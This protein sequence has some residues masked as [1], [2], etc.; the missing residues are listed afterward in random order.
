ML[1]YFTAGTW[2]AMI[3]MTGPRLHLKTQGTVKSGP[4]VEIPTFSEHLKWG[5]GADNYQEL[6]DDDLS[7]HS[8]ATEH[9]VTKSGARIHELN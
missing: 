8:T 2:Y 5:L 1:L 3:A 4:E 6:S 9:E 7:Q